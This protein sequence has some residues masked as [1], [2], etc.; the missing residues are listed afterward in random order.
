MRAPDNKKQTTLGYRLMVVD[1]NNIARAVLIRQLQAA[2]YQVEGAS[3]GPEALI[4]LLKVRVHLILLDFVMQPLSGLEV[5]QRIRAI[6][7][8]NRL[9]VVMMSATQDADLVFRATQLGA[10]DFFFG[11]FNSRNCCTR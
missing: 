8:P 3:T 5:L 10:N 9:P 11:P 6:Y 1:D 7:P 4:A 2:G